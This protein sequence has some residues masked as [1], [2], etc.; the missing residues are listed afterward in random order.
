MGRSPAADLA[1]LGVDLEVADPEHGRRHL[2][3]TA[4]QRL[5]PG[6]QFLERERLG[7]VVVRAGPERRDLRLERVLRGQHQDGN[8]DAAVA[9]GADHLHPVHAGKAEI[10]HGEVVLAARDEPEPLEAV[11]DEVGVVVLLLQ[12]V[13]DVLAHGLVVFDDDDL[14]AGTV[15]TRGNEDPE[16]GSTARLTLHGDAPAVLLDDAVADGEAE[17]GPAPR[18]L[19]GVERLEDLVERLGRNARRRCRRTPPSPRRRG[20]HSRRCGCGACRPAP[21]RRP[22]SA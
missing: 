12:A 1:G 6:Q 22:R 15:A 13:L 4:R 10:E 17:A 19:G 18:R 3:G 16:G 8:P 9:Q 7:H 5:D 20:R 2:A 21:S 11:I 14:H